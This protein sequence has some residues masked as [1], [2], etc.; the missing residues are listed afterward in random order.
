MN[1]TTDFVK[2]KEFF[3]AKMAFTTGTSELAGKIKRNE[4]IVIVD[5]RMPS[6]YAKGYIPGAI[7]LPNGKWRG[8]QG[9]ARD[10]IH[11]VYCYSQTCRLAAAAALEFATQGYPVME[12]EGGFAAWQAGGYPVETAQAALA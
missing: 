7:H 8:A 11:I 5:V 2:A 1:P 3:A 10:K 4:D 9:L 6:D 12:M